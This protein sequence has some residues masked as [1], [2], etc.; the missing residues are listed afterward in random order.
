LEFFGD[1]VCY[2]VGQGVYVVPQSPQHVDIE[3]LLQQLGIVPQAPCQIAP[4]VDGDAEETL[5][6]MLSRNG[7]YMIGQA[8]IVLSGRGDD[9]GLQVRPEF[10]GLFHLGINLG[11]RKL[12]RRP[13][14]LRLALHASIVTVFLPV[15]IDA[16]LRLAAAAVAHDLGVVP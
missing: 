7:V 16:M 13:F 12:R 8:Y 11:G 9:V 2:R 15:N 6:C 1:A 3:V 10:L 14:A 4:A 5:L